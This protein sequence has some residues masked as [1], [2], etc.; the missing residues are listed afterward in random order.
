MQ[1][2]DFRFIYRCEP[3]VVAIS[4]NPSFSGNA[5]AGAQRSSK[6]IQTVCEIGVAAGSQV[7]SIPTCSTVVNKSW[8]DTLWW[9]G[10]QCMGR[11]EMSQNDLHFH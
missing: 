2:N 5:E 7:T 8:R 10:A 3:P 4:T 11:D 1:H 6:H 9:G